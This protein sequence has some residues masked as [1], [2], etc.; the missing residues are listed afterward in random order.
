MPGKKILAEMKCERDNNHA[1][2]ISIEEGLDIFQKLSGPAKVT[3]WF[4]LNFGTRVADINRVA[5]EQ[6]RLKAGD[7]YNPLEYATTW[8]R[9]TMNRRCKHNQYSIRLPLISITPQ[10]VV[11]ALSIGAKEIME[12][13]EV[14]ANNACLEVVCP[15]VATLKVPS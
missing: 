14:D 6:M 15:G 2:D 1:R 10:E 5:R 13:M 3:A 7:A 4:Q 9:L 11:T 8:L 12:T